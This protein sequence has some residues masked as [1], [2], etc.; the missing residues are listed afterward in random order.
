MEQTTPTSRRIIDIESGTAMVV[1]DLHGDGDAYSRYRDRFLSLHAS[2]QADFLFVLGD[3]L[4]FSGPEEMD[5]SLEIILDLIRLK[6]EH[7]DKVVCLLGNH[8]LPHIY[9]ITLQ[10]G[11]QLLTPRFENQLQQHRGVVID[12]LHDLPFFIRTKAGVALCHAGASPAVTQDDGLARLANFSHREL[13]ERAR[14]QITVEERPSLMRAMHQL[15]NQT[16][17]EMARTY[18]DIQSRDDPRYDDFLIGTIAS[19]DPDFALLWN[20]LFTRNEHEFGEAP[21]HFILDA[22]LLALSQSYRP[23][24]FLVSGHINVRGGHKLIH[25]KQL[26]LASAHHAV[27]RQAGK[28]LLFD[29]GG[30]IQNVMTLERGLGSVF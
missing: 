11:D 21:Y 22:M 19:S 29:T 24:K 10:R 4:H 17:N 6:Q 1:T 3:M 27:P 5:Q 7:G 18:F 23:Q 13:L 30:S 8:E 2:G 16:Y 15:N 26:R 14:D 25:N 12:F 20:T 9:S 28:Y